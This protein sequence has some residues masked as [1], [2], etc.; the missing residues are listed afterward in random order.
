L[1]EDDIRHFRKVSTEA[2]LQPLRSEL[3]ER[4]AATQN[5]IAGLKLR[6]V[7]LTA[8]LVLSL[9]YIVYFYVVPSR[10]QR[11]R[12]LPTVV[13]LDVTGPGL[14]DARTKVT[15]TTRI[16]GYL[17]SITVDRNDPVKTDQI[18]AKLE[19]EE[20]ANQL[21]VAEA[22]A[23]A[24]ERAVEEARSD[25][26]REKAIADK[27]R[28]ESERKRGLVLRGVITEADWTATESAVLQTQADLARSAA[29]VERAIA[30]AAS[31]AANVKVLKARLNEAT[32]YSPL[33]GVVVM[34]DR[35]VGDLL[36]PGTPLM[37][38]VDPQSLVVSARFDESAMGTIKAG[39]EAT[40]RF[41][42]LPDK[43]F[44][45]TVLR[46]I[47]QVDQETREFT[48]DIILAV[49]PDHWAIGQRA[50]V[51]V[52]A[53]SPTRIITIPQILIARQQGRVGVW[54]S[55]DGRAEWLPLTLGYPAGEL[56]EVVSGLHEGDVLLSPQG[57]Y[58]L[59]PVAIAGEAK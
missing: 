12:V 38:I 32:I 50:N 20:L 5:R 14:V 24:A 23:E 39:Q 30:Q 54:I 45:G 31:S 9:G 17:K 25:Q 8:L 55:K 34:R 29:T 51:T 35:N 28:K 47:R 19:S 48:V 42:S 40:V 53:P 49:L 58:W 6:E 15:I 10:I 33:N 52:K 56:V 59:E 1:K 22:D 13:D 16:Q 43:A 26:D 36:S 11:H 4:G 46:L 3:W 7:P 41:A 27:A 37:E 57:R 18:L 2:H 44:D 21:N